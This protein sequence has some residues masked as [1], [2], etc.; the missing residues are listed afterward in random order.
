MTNPE[1]LVVGMTIRDYATIHIAAAY[2]AKCV[3]QPVKL[4]APSAV[5][6][7]TRSMVDAL[8]LEDNENG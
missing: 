7:Y 5:V 3:D 8:L 6:D 4:P 2:I 1:L